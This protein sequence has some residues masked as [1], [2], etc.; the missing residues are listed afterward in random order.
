[1]RHLQKSCLIVFVAPIVGYL[2]FFLLYPL[3]YGICISFY[4]YS[5]GSPTKTWVGLY[6]YVTLIKDEQ[7]QKALII[8]TVF[9]AGVVCLEMLLGIGG[10]FLLAQEN[11]LMQIIR[12]TILSPTVFAPLVVGLL[13]KALYQPDL[14]IISYYLRKLNIP[15][16][17]GLTVERS[18]ALLAVILVDVWE[19][20]PL[21]LIIILA[22][23]KN[24]PR[25]PYEAAIVD[26]AS[27]WQLFRYIT[28][29]LLRPFVIVALLIRSL[30]ALKAFDVIWAITGGGPGTAT[31]VV[32]LRIFE[33]GIQQLRIGYAATMSNILLTMSLLIG[34]IFIWI[35]YSKR[36]TMTL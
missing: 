33:I 22:G 7:F 12:T 10:A 5:L 3:I 21:V 19:W 31:T 25:E 2:C 34:G 32:N 14:G 8:T 20:F 26:G 6:N 16:N 17:R 24:L 23:L 29:P 11:K 9:V 30:D 28:F 36:Y 1:M 18:T 15:I 27:S 35:F 4:D 13:W